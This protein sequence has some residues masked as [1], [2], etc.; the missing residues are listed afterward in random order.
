MQ[1]FIGQTTGSLSYQQ[2]DGVSTGNVA[3]QKSLPLGTGFG[4]R[5]QASANQNENR[6]DTLL[7]YQGPYGRY[8]AGYD[9]SKGADSTVLS[10]AGGLAVIGGSIFPTRAVQESFALIQVP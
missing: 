9:R 5:F 4:Y 7:Q 1:F 6:L 8:E 2:R 3:L 10:A